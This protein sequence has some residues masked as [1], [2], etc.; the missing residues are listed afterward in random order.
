M[1]EDISSTHNQ[2]ILLTLNIWKIHSINYEKSQITVDKW[3]NLEQ[4]LL[5]KD[6]QVTNEHTEDLINNQTNANLNH[7]KIISHTYENF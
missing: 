1:G 4:T 7:S 6:I 5:K 3:K 2:Q